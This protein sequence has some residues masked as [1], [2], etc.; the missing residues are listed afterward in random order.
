M[1]I[2]ICLEN[3]KL[4]NVEIKNRLNY[5]KHYEPSS[6]ELKV[7]LFYL[8]KKTEQRK[9]VIQNS[10]SRNILL[11]TLPLL[12]FLIFFRDKLIVF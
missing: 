1:I 7:I 11:K 2:K 9:S 12:D 4:S 5:R 10:C 3:I 8:K 6:I